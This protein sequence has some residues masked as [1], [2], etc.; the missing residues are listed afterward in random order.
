MKTMLLEIARWA[1]ALAAVISLVL[2]FR[3]DPVSTADPVQVTA[4]VTQELDMS[5]MLQADNQMLRRLYGLE[6]SDFDSCV[7]YY[8]ATNMGAEE[9]LI[10]KL[11]DVSQAE[12]VS[13]AAQARLET[14]KTT[15][16]GYGVEQYALLTSH[17][18]LEVRGNY[19]LFVVH[20]QAEEALQ[21][22]LDAL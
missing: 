20:G 14:Q 10:V 16:D 7:L 9:L 21:A 4:A 2:M 22:F 17:S 8:P 18:V 15:F 11:R 13:A 6:P 3:A 12:A 1:V 19:V 5:Q